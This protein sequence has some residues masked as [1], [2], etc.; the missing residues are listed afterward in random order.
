M[1]I[2]VGCYV[3]HHVILCY[4]SFVYMWKVRGYDLIGG[5]LIIY[6]V[7]LMI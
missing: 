4:L 2:N 6:K 7:R 1:E 5:D 3:I